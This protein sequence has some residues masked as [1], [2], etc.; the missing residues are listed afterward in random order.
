MYEIHE[1]FFELS[2]AERMQIIAQ[3][4]QHERDKQFKPHS[5]Q[6]RFVSSEITQTTV[7]LVNRT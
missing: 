4:R 6:V 5:E 3:S 7:R 2:T 1:I